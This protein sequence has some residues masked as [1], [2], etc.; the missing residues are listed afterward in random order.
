MAIEFELK[1]RATQQIQQALLQEMPGNPQ[2]F[3][4]QTTYYDT[5]SGSLSARWYTLRQRMENDVSVCTLKAP[6]GEE[7]RGE[8]EVNC[9]CIEDA[10]VELCKLD[11]PGDFA[12]LTVQGV[13]P[14]CGAK[15]TRIAKTLE[16]PDCIVEL[17]LDSGILTGG[18]K[19]APLCEVEVELKSGSREG[20]YAY[21]MALAGTFGLEREF[22]SKFRR[23]LALTEGV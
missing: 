8:W 6:A 4:M 5:P 22:T 18:G 14:I 10:I 13:I 7:A 2:Q 23:A 12:E 3:T 17:A 20:A 11:I 15:F 1:Y 21:A 9:H 19:E 16:L